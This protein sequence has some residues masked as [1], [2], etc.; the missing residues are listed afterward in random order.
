MHRVSNIAQENIFLE[1]WRTEMGSISETM[2][3][4]AE[5]TIKH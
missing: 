3:D 4:E 5:A 1:I 2:R